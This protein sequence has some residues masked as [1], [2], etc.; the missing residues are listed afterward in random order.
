MMMKMGISTQSRIEGS[1]TRSSM[2]PA[3]TRLACSTE[4]GLLRAAPRGIPI[5]SD[6]TRTATQKRKLRPRSTS[7]EF[8]LSSFTPHTATL[9]QP[10]SP[11]PRA[12]HLYKP[13]SRAYHRAYHRSRR[14]ALEDPSSHYVTLQPSP[15][16]V[17]PPNEADRPL[18]AQPLEGGVSLASGRRAFQPHNPPGLRE[19][20]KAVEEKARDGSGGFTLIGAGSAQP[21]VLASEPRGLGPAI[22]DGGVGMSHDPA[23]N[24]PA[25][26]STSAPRD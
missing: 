4:A 8:S 25:C 21:A 11:S 20:W 17:S 16:R 19:T 10:S 13:S 12:A 26:G 24:F 7:E 14:P 15:L 2:A 1:S 9:E 3:A 22:K 18:R 6:N 5:Y 23:R